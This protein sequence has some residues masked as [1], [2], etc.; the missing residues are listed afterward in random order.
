MKKSYETAE[1]N[2]TLFNDEVVIT[3][4]VVY[5]QESKDPDELPLIPIG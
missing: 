4:S 3:A 2:I 1:I 5:E